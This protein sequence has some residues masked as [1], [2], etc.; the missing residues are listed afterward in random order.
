MPEVN[1]IYVCYVTVC[2]SCYVMLCL[3]LSLC[4]CVLLL[5]KK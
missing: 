5:V 3:C 4:V 1:D 2:M